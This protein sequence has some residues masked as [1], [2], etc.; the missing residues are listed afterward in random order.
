M[1]LLMK[2]LFFELL[3]PLEEPTT[4]W[5]SLYMYIVHICSYNYDIDADD[6]A[7]DALGER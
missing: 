4:W 7:D 1:L 5:R 2:M 3:I 6:D